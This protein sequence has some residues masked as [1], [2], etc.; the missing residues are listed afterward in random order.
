MATKDVGG[1]EPMASRLHGVGQRRGGCRLGSW[2]A[3]RRLVGLGAGDVRRRG[4]G[5]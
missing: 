4:R 2:V 3:G 5:R 1:A